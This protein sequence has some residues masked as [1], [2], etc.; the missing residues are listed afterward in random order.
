MCVDLLKYSIDF[1]VQ[2]SFLSMLEE[3]DRNLI[4]GKI[5]R[6]QL[7]LKKVFGVLR[8]NLL[9]YMYIFLFYIELFLI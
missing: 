9:C 6:I 7:S 4:V 2:A 1:L 8:F 5:F 3:N